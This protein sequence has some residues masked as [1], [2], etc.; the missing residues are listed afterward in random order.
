MPELAVVHPGVTVPVGT[1]V[2]VA[3]GEGLGVDDLPQA[4]RP[5]AMSA[6]ATPNMRGRTEVSRTKWR[7]PF[8]IASAANCG[9]GR[10]VY[11]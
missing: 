10:P 1:G 9:A 3:V 6:T 8:F 5:S 4:A 2:G 11:C 7:V